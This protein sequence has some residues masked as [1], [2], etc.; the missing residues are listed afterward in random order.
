M[1]QGNVLLLLHA[2]LPFV[3]HPEHE[4][5][6]EEDWLYEAI[7]ETYLPIL[8]LAE[9]LEQERVTSKFS[10]A[11]SP[12]LCEM[13]ADPLLQ[14]RYLRRLHRL[15][16]LSEREVQRTR[17]EPLFNQTAR[18]YL[19]SFRRARAVFEDEHGRNILRGFRRLQDAGRIEILT[20]G[21]THGFF[22]LMSRVEAVRAQ[23]RV[24]ASNYEKHFGRRPDGIWLPE[25][26]FQPGHDAILA[27]EGVTHFCVETHAIA[28]AAPRPKYTI[29]APVRTPSGVCAFGRDIESSRQVWSASEGYPGDVDYREFYRDLGYDGDEEYVKPYLHAD[30][31]RRNLGIKYHRITG[32]VP[33]DQ[34][35]PYNPAAAAHRARAHAE[36]FLFNRVEQARHLRRTLHRTASVLSPY[37]AELFGHWWYEGPQFLVELLRL[38]GRQSEV[39]F[40]TPR[41]V[42][43]AGGPVQR[44]TPTLSTWGDKG[45]CEVWLNPTNDWIYR[46]QHVVEDRMASLARDHR[47]ASGLL[48]RALNQA[49]RETLL[50]Q[51]SDW[52]FIMNADTAV[53]YAHKRFKTHVEAFANLHAQIRAGRIEETLVSSLESRHNA[54]AEIDWR[55]FGPEEG[56]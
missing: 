13:L 34:K 54:F 55:V 24:A 28:Y 4:E 1:P 42:L 35:Q 26:G 36:N 14:S 7:T 40:T 50:A 2:H 48:R 17:H 49:A 16:D 10:I 53:P 23:V 21:A 51:S 52:A 12:P 41:D 6:L 20:C 22:P 45:Y 38:A 29:Y 44:S 46:H 15:I 39:N 9:N 18:H 8:E 32:R 43:A 47:D 37:D 19:E 25:C 5:F 31:V 30:G 11:L 3:R 27:A 56:R 33:L